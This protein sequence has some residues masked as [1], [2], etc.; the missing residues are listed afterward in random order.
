MDESFGDDLIRALGERRTAEAE[1][2]A[3]AD[4]QQQRVARATWEA[5]DV[6]D[7]L[8]NE[9]RDEL[10]RRRVPTSAVRRARRKLSGGNLASRLT[11]P[12]GLTVWTLV[13]NHR[14]GNQTWVQFGSSLCLT[15]EPRPRLVHIPRHP[16]PLYPTDDITDVRVGVSGYHAWPISPGKAGYSASDSDLSGVPY[17]RAQAGNQDDL[18][19]WQP[20]KDWLIERV[21][22]LV[23]PR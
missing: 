6:L 16:D 15:D 23:E 1:Q 22:N 4:E 11:K 13:G 5:N 10:R 7:R 18:A 14:A 2:K 21:A 3:Q 8:L 9:V 20:M 17:I 19:V 12:V